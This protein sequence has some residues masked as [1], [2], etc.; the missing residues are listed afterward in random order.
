MNTE[1]FKVIIQNDQ[2]H[3]EENTSSEILNVLKN[4]IENNKSLIKIS[5]K[6]SS[7]FTTLLLNK[8]TLTI[9]SCFSV[10]LSLIFIF[11]KIEFTSY[12]FFLYLILLILLL[13]TSTIA[14]LGFSS[15]FETISENRIESF[16]TTA[17]YDLKSY[18]Q[19][20][21]YLGETF[22]EENLKDEEFRFKLA[23]NQIKGKGSVVE[24]ITP[25]LAIFFVVVS[26]LILGFPSENDEVKFLLGTIAGISGIVGFVKVML[27]AIF[28]WLD[29]QII[30]VHEKCILILQAAQLIAK[31][32]E[33]DAVRVYDQALSHNDEVIPFEQA[34]SEIERNR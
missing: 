12:T 33:L 20:I 32:E 24:K 11:F 31:E 9:A 4:F 10:F 28:K 3:K 25:F 16:Y 19:T 26:I 29:Y 21:E 18:H 2:D 22:Y 1:P 15:L 14:I 13:I 6:K 34:I 27:D 17:S 5:R 30:D 7:N 8:W 23:V